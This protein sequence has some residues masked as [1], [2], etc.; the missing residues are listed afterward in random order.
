MG[1]VIEEGVMRRLE[2]AEQAGIDQGARR[3]LE[4]AP[5]PAP[6]RQGYFIAPRVLVDAPPA[7]HAGSE[8]FGPL[9]TVHPVKDVDEAIAA[10]NSSPFGLSSSIMTRS[11]KGALGVAERLR[12][13]VVRINGSTTGLEPHVPISGAGES[14][15]NSISFGHEALEF[16]TRLQTLYLDYS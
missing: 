9:L 1:P 10:A 16:F 14:G 13:G 2:A 11:L 15:L 4:P 8:I 3:L 7:L 6:L 5:I 12:V